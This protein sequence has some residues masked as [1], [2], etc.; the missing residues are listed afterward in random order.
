MPGHRTPV[1]DYCA[2]AAVEPGM[3]PASA[4]AYADDPFGGYQEE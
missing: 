2:A 3:P 4:P 1:A